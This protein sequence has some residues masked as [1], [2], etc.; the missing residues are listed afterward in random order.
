MNLQEQLDGMRSRF[1]TAAPPETLAVMHHA[2]ETLRSSGLLERT[3]QKNQHAPDFAL[4]DVYGEI[5][6][7]RELL[8]KGPLVIVFYR[9]VW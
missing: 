3:L 4:P 8:R 1:E 6:S 5:V 7:T 2:T 9:G